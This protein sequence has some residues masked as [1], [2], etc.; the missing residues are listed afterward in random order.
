MDV[1]SFWEVGGE[2][3]ESGGRLRFSLAD[4][5][6][7]SEFSRG[8]VVNQIPGQQSKAGKEKNCDDKVRYGVGLKESV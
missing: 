7:R 3:A 6:V 1:S 4:V 2:R 8:G 5:K